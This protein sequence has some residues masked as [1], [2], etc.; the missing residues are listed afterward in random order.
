[1]TRKGIRILSRVVEVGNTR[2]YLKIM[3]LVLTIAPKNDL[4]TL[5]THLVI[6]LLHA[7]S[8]SSLYWTLNCTLM[9]WKVR[10]YFSKHYLAF[11][12]TSHCTHGPANVQTKHAR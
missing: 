9:R 2:E 5:Y 4:V 6:G 3:R 11:V 1:M 10:E 7:L 12:S 8:I